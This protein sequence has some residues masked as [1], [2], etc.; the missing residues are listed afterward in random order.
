MAAL[1]SMN[2]DAASKMRADFVQFESEVAASRSRAEELHRENIRL[3]AENAVLNERCADFETL[4]EEVRIYSIGTLAPLCSN[5]SQ[6]ERLTKVNEDLSNGMTS[7]LH[8]LHRVNFDEYLDIGSFR[9]QVSFTD[10]LISE[11]LPALVIL[12]EPQNGERR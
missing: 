1:Q 2:N 5:P 4:R 10:H 7:L 11:L 9:A 8:R 12:H 6:C 3:Q